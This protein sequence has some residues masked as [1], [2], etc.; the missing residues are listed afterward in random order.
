V[1][2]LP[3]VAAHKMGFTLREVQLVKIQPSIPA[4]AVPAKKRPA[5]RRPAVRPKSGPR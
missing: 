3:V 2:A 5:T 4:R 1:P